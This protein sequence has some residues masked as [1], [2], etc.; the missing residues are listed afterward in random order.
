MEA[1]LGQNYVDTLP[2]TQKELSATTAVR[3]QLQ[4]ALHFCFIFHI[5]LFCLYHWTWTQNLIVKRL[6][7]N[8][9]LSVIEVVMAEHIYHCVSKL[10]ACSLPTCSPLSRNVLFGPEVESTYT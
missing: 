3:L 9:P 5:L 4:S 8:S 10:M 1:H 7:R 6:L 2:V